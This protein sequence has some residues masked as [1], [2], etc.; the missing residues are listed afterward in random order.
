MN[1]H[2]GKPYVKHAKWIASANMVATA[3]VIDE[4]VQVVRKLYEDR[5]TSS[6]T[7]TEDSESDDAILDI[8]VSFDGTS[9]T[10]GHKS[11]SESDDAIL[12]ITV[13]FDG[14]SMTRGHKSKYGLGCVIEI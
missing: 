10:R 11:K 4:A 7:L 1:V 12:D 2:T 5:D 13:S 6:I 3:S 9:M 14:T 8:T